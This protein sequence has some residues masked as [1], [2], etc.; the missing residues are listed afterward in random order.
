VTN[1]NSTTGLSLRMVA[2]LWFTLWLMEQPHE[3][4]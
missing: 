1:G 2:G 4:N 3:R